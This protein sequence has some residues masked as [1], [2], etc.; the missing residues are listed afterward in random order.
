[1]SGASEATAAMANREPFTINSPAPVINPAASQS[2]LEQQMH[3][4]YTPDGAAGY[5]QMGSSPLPYQPL[6]AGA[7][8]INHG[9][10][11]NSADQKRKRGRP[12]KYGPDGSMT[13]PLGSPQQPISVAMQQQQPQTF[14]PP[15]AAPPLAVQTETHPPM[16]GSASPT[17]KKAR[18]RP[19]GSR[20]KKQHIE[21]LGNLGCEFLLFK[22]SSSEK[23][24]SFNRILFPLHK[25]SGYD[26]HHVRA[27]FAMYV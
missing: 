27:C 15:S 3:M 18:G 9:V 26:R 1:M 19:R 8:V 22:G 12:R 25:D 4:S 13:I 2:Q 10:N 23:I 14:S 6:P 5:R 16:D 17:A 24:S 11:L 7:T 21:A 20:N